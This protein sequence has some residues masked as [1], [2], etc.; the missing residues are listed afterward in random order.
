MVRIATAENFEKLD[1]SK[2][3]CGKYAD[4]VPLRYRAR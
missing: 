3:S 2:E 1:E 4:S